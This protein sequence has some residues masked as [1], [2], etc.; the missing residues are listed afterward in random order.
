MRDRTMTHASLCTGIGACEL[1]ATWMGWENLFS[2]EIDE[3]C[4][5]VL[6]YHYPNSVHYGNIFEQD[7]R[8][9][10]GRIDI[11]TAGFP[12]FVAGTPVLTRKG[13]LPIEDVQVG[14]EVLTTDRTYHPVECTM[15]HDAD[16]IIY[17]RAQGMFKELKCTPN[18]PFYV[19]ARKG[20]K[21]MLPEYIHASD[22]KKGDK[23]GYPIHEGDDTS[24]TPAFWELVGT[25]LADGWCDNNKRSGRKNSYNHKTI[26]CCG[27]HNITRLHHVIQRAGYKYTLTEDKSIY[28]AIICDEWLCDFLNDFGKYAHG[29][30]LSPQCFI[31]DNARKKSLLKGWFADGYVCQNGSI[32]ITT[33]SEK[34]SLDMAQIARDVYRCPVSISK[35]TSKRTCIIDGRVV[36]ERPQF[37]I[38]IS[39]SDRYGFYENGFVWCNVKSIRKEKESNTVYNL[40]VNEEHSY[41]VYGIAVHNCQPFSVAGARNGAEDDRYLWPEVLRVI[42]EVRPTWFI[43]ENVSGIITMVL[44][45]EETKVGSYTDVCGESYTMCEKRQRYVIE[46]IRIDLASIGYSVQPVVIP[47]CAVGAPHRR[48]RVWFL[49]RRDDVTDTGGAGLQETGTQQRATGVAGDGI[50]GITTN[51]SESGFQERV[52]DGKRE[53][54]EETRTRED[55]GLERLGGKQITTYSQ[56]VG[57]DKIHE[58]LQPEQP[59]GPIVDSIGGERDAADPTEQRLQGNINSREQTEKGRNDHFREHVTGLGKPTDWRN[60]PTQSPV[61]KRYDGIS[62]NVVRYI[63]QE[64]YDAIKE[65]IRREDLPR[66]WEA[67]QE[68]EIRGKIGRL[69]EIPEPDI[70]LEILQRTSKDERPESEQ[71]M[72]SCFSKET[73]ERILCYLRKHGTFTSSSLGQKYQEQFTRE[74]G[75]TMCDLSHEIAL[76]TKKI[77]D[78]CETT[79]LRWRQESIKA[80]GNSMVPPLVYEIFLAIEK[81]EQIK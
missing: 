52:D 44:P 31:L 51:P 32:K 48:D 15:K 72:L 67:F 47:A 69:Y 55:D 64:V 7:F 36:N 71:E 41:N 38:T 57:S 8:E 65:Y 5:K 27:K 53:V 40:A 9:W 62:N 46:Q 73:S 37:C 58:N 21:F 42:S 2:C 22:L 26:I 74:F 61:R 3:F 49:A 76:A 13:F 14:D 18:H 60:F 23:I 56:R 16:E 50:Q 79:R 25:W 78:E 66:V 24:F 45:G 30:H 20:R 1:A 4:N 77:I 70:L 75:D 68:K 59:D 11:L 54:A 81:V 29:K 17:L 34:L 12:C 10:R 33:V 63:N 35:K 28:K 39:R 6:K 19:R 80:L 43:G